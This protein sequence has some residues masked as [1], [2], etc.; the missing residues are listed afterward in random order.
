ME[1]IITLIK[2]KNWAE[3]LNYSKSMTNEERYSTIEI[4]KGIDIDKYIVKRDTSKLFGQERE[5]YFQNRRELETCQNYFFVTCIR[6]FD[7]LRKVEIEEEFFTENPFYN[8]ISTDNF[9]PLIEF[10]K[11]FPPNY[12]NKVI[13]ELSKENF[14]NFNFKTLWKCYENNWVD[15]DEEFFLRRLLII[16][17]FDRS[18]VE[19]ANFLLHNIEALEKV[20]LKFY[21]YET[22]ILD[23]SK[24]DAREGIVCKKVYEFWTEVIVIL[25]E[26]G[27][28]FDRSIITNLF[29]SLLNN[30]TRPHLDWHVRL[31]ELFQPTKEELITNQ[32]T[33]ISI[34]GTGQPSLINFVILKIKVIY[35]DKN[36]DTL[37][38]MDN[39]PIIFS[40]NKI[41]KSLFVVLEII[42]HLLAKSVK[43]SVEF[44]EL[45]CLLFIQTDTK[46]QEKVAKILVQYFNDIQLHTI[47]F[48]YSQN[49]KQIAKDIL[50]IKH[51]IS[52][53][54]GNTISINKVIREII[55]LRTWDE[56]LLHIGTCIRTKSAKDIEI[57]FESIIQLQALIP[58]DYEKQIKPYTKNLFGK[59]YESDTLTAFIF[60]LHSWI[61]EST[62]EFLKMEFKYL[63]FLGKK[64]QITYLKLK[65][66]VYYHFSPPQL[67][68]HFTFIPKF[69]WKEY[70]NTREIMKLLI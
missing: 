24:W 37:T 50:K 66:K 56:L 20:F 69:Y 42:E 39:V 27:Y 23:I 51:N 8:F 49:L 15:F 21:K 12:L 29:E 30:W 38:F 2:N 19:D 35:Q 9:K 45:L 5:E 34:L 46:I 32:S 31:L 13:K 10:Y 55:P 65:G 18:T 44:R 1:K 4:L 28:I 3:I 16:H 14:R 25:Q 63:P 22:P 33:L 11:L 60:F 40:N 41:T 17:M 6:N 36:F 70:C 67:M 52:E 62:D 26:R 57:F 47:V 53:D 43:V 54:L 64:A 58:P 61:A 48:P 7:D 59:Y 68:N